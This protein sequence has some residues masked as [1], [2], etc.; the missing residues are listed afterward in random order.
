MATS[1]SEVLK[2][3]QALLDS[4][5]AGDYDTYNSF[6]AADVTCF[7]PESTGM[8]VHGTSFHKFYF[9]L[10]KAIDQGKTDNLQADAFPAT[11]ISMSNPH[12]R[13]LGENAVV[14]S[15]VRVDQALDENK[16][17]VTRT[18]SETRIW[19]KREK[20]AAGDKEWNRELCIRNKK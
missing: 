20:G 5:A 16:A 15:Y 4:I 19:E 8:L 11:N 7:E 12:L 9:D 17:P 14:L 1:E 2:A 13:W 6:C 10:D 18:K 3:N